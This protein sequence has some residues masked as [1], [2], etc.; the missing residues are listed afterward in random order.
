MKTSQ[1]IYKKSDDYSIN[2]GG[3]MIKSIKEYA[4]PKNKFVFVGL[5]ALKI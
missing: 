3:D 5:S 1:N 4:H 2:V